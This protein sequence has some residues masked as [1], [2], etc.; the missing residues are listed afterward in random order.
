MVHW[1][2]LV[3]AHC[4]F[5]APASSLGYHFTFNHV[6]YRFSG[7]RQFLRPALFLVTL[8]VVRIGKLF[9]RMFLSWDF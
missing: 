4:S 6:S 9:Y 7:L 8:T 3:F 2:Y 1:E 5:S